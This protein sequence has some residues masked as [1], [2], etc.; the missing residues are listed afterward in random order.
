MF[1]L[2]MVK[3]VGQLVSWTITIYVVR[4]LSPTDYG[5]MAMAGVYL[6]FI[7][8]FNEVGLGT[9]IVQRKEL[10]REDLSGI[11]WTVLLMNVALYGLSVL[12]APVV[13]AF[14]NEPRVA[15]VIRVA[16]VVFIIRS[17]G[18]VSYNMLTREMMFNR[19]SQA[20]MIG[21]LSGAVATLVLAMKG[22]GVWSLVYGNIAIELI[23]NVLYLQ[24]YRWTPEFSLSFSRVRGMI[25]FGSKVALSRL[26]WYLSS[27]LDLLIAGKILGQSQLGYYAIAVQFASIPLDKMVATISQVAFP[28]FSR[29]QDDR[30]LLKR[31][32]L[33]IVKVVGFVSFPLCCGGFLVAESAV[34]LFLS[35]KWTP[36]ILPLQILSIVAAFRAIHIMNAPL[37]IAIGKPGITTLNFLIMLPVLALSFFIGS[38]YGLEG[39][40]YSWLVF[41]VLFL[42]TTSI[43]LNLV[44]LSLGEYIKELR[45]PF[46][47]SVFMV[48]AVLLIQRA[49]LIN[50]GLV[51]QVAGS[52]ALGLA[53]YASY[54]FF[55]N[56][57]IFAE[58]K[59][60]LKR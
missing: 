3:V 32:Y 35:D 15:E 23:K 12:S 42:I 52:M 38:S 5:L 21:N 54:Y 4:I 17:L 49:V 25:H 51:A 10:A 19:Q 36:A 13:A 6:S 22:F 41:P 50:L 9:A 30:A 34:P 60:M 16:S 40:A 45:H 53:S 11:Y 56:R 46:L 1:W 29:V 14:Y 39:L 20:E 28:A 2:T 59:G 7:I 55:F 37:E 47:G 18:L 44:G 27:R 48:A 26:C 57:E 33:R 24:F 8:L 43:S 58:A 31:Y